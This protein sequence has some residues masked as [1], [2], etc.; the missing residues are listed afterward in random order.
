MSLKGVV[1]FAIHIDGFRNIDLFHQGLYQVR[2]CI[3]HEKDGQKVFAHPYHTSEKPIKDSKKKENKPIIGPHILDETSSY[4]TRTFLIRF[5]DEET[6]FNEIC[7]FRTEYDAFPELAETNFYIEAELMF[8]DLAKLSQPKNG[9]EDTLASFK[10]ISLFKA[11][12]NNIQAGVH[13]YLPILFDDNHF[14]ILQTVFHAVLMDLKFRTSPIEVPREQPP[15][16]GQEKKP[17]VVI[18]PPAKNFTEFLQRN[19]QNFKPHELDKFHNYYI[20]ALRRSYEKLVEFHAYILK[21]CLLGKNKQEFLKFYEKAPFFA[22]VEPYIGQSA[23]VNKVH[24]IFSDLKEEMQIPE[25]P[26]KLFEGAPDKKISDDLN[27]SDPGSISHVIM[28]EVNMIAG[29]VFQTW[30][31]LMDM[32]Q[33]APKFIVNLLKEEYHKQL[34]DRWGESIFQQTYK[35][36]DLALSFEQKVGETH[37]QIASARRNNLY[38]KVLDL[39]HAIEDVNMFPKP[40]FHPILFEE[41]YVKEIAG[42]EKS[43]ESLLAE[44]EKNLTKAD[45]RGVHLIVFSHGFQGNSFDLRLFKNNISYLYPDTLFLCA[46]ANEDLTDG[47]INGMGLRLANEVK[48]YIE[49]WVPGNNLGRLSFIGHSLGGLIIRSALPHLEQFAPKMHLFMTLSSP[50]LGYMYNS[51]KIIDAG[52]WFLKK[53]KKSTCLQELTMTDA[54]N[55]EDTYLFKL[56]KNKGLEWFKTVVLL[57][58]YQDMYAPFE[59]ARIQTSKKATQE[60]TRGSVW[61]NMAKNILS[62]ITTDCVYRIDINFKLEEKNLDTMIGRAAHI[63]FLESQALMRMITYRYANFFG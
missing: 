54:P 63:K 49:E 50:H 40:E 53:W 25:K 36:Q 43:A 7:H 11:K 30:Y 26:K 6:D 48:N 5:C 10:C 56:S 38:Y 17:P 42:Q 27:P 9:Q 35:V 1:E 24:S 22:I 33:E 29:N 15:V 46:S 59:S 8:A 20:K 39:Y 28:Q 12:L 45:Y 62:N 13:E 21:I 2:I 31:L 60:S 18:I 19:T 34:K 52:M 58:S 41:L 14:C 51:S 23:V 44:T 4:V 55:M 47:E 37:K 32:M 61:A 16:N 3:Y 57:S